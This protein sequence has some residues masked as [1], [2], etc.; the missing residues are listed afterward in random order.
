L[1]AGVSLDAGGAW[2]GCWSNARINERRQAESAHVLIVPTRNEEGAI[3]PALAKVPR[4][5]VDR[6]IVADGN[7][8]IDGGEGA[9]GGPRG[10]SRRVGAT[11]APV[12][13]ARS[14]RRTS[15]S[16]L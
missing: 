4:H 10:E 5:R 16:R 3:G 8:T 7:S 11:G 12:G 2:G 1:S 13:S 15:D 14:R 9:G 6:I